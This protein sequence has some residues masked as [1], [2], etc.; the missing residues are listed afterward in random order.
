MIAFHMRTVIQIL[1]PNNVCYYHPAQRIWQLQISGN[2]IVFSKLRSCHTRLHSP[3]VS[4]YCYISEIAVGL[5]G[6]SKTLY[7]QLYFKFLQGENVT[8]SWPRDFYSAPAACN[9]IP[10]KIFTNKWLHSN[11]V[12][13][14]CLELGPQVYCLCVCAPFFIS[15][16]IT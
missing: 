13:I 2:L 3:R 6:N 7:M 8:A 12:L 1:H 4:R 14:M 11:W 16:Y 9:C 10:T 15:P 5:R